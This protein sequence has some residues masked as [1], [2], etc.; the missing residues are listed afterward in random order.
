MTKRQ[1]NTKRKG[2]QTAYY[3]EH[4]RDEHG[5]RVLEPL[6]TN[7]GQAKEKWGQIEN[8]KVDAFAESTLGDVYTQYMTWAKKKK[9][10]KLSDR[11]IKDRENYWRKLKPVFG[12]IPIDE[13]KAHWLLKYYEERNSQIGAKKEIKFLSVIFNWAKARDLFHIENPVAGVTRQ[14]SVNEHREILISHDEFND[15]RKNAISWLQDYMD[16]MYLTGSRPQEALDLKFSH[17]KDGELIYRQGK[18]KRM[19]RMVIGKDL[20][21]LINRRR[22]LLKKSKITLIDPPLLFDDDGKP[23]Q[24]KRNVRYRWKQA[25]D[26]TEMSRRWTLKDIR[27]YAAT[28]RYKKEGIEAT[29]K[30]LGHSTEA[31]TRKYIREYLGEETQAHELPESEKLA[32]VKRENG[33]S[34]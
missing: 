28:E 30:F 25:R 18:T 34:S 20:R 31:Q 23:L 6:G 32:K 4:P 33:E 21:V 11:T 15:V 12:H 16:L 3:Y 10:S 9:L 5:R 14:L 24:L 17:E 29:R 26:A 22:K 19:K 8:V 7:F 2:I 27:P 1:W 13:F